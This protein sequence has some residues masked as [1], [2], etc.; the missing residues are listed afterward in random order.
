MYDDP[1]GKG[2]MI[3]ASAPVYTKEGFFG[4]LG[5]DVTLN[6]ISKNIEL[7]QPLEQS[8]FFLVNKDGY[9]I[10]LPEQAWKDILGRNREPGEVRANLNNLTNEFAAILGRMKEGNAGFGGVIIGD[11]HY[12]IAYAPLK[13]TG[14]SLGMVTEENFCLKPL[15]TWRQK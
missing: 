1:A 3:T 13:E 14:F 11:K 4:V 10:A 5:M 12:Y 9:S 8:Y 7:Y 15:K 6:K 2:L